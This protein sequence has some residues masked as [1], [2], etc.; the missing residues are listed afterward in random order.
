ML[1]TRPQRL[2]NGSLLSAA[3]HWM[4]QHGRRS[5]SSTKKVNLV[6][7][8]RMRGTASKYFLS[9][10]IAVVFCAN[11]PTF[12]MYQIDAGRTLTNGSG[13]PKNLRYHESMALSLLPPGGSHVAGDLFSSR[14]D[15]GLLEDNAAFS[16]SFT[17][18]CVG[19][20]TEPPLAPAHRCRGASHLLAHLSTCRPSH[21]Y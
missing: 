19:T 4:R 21:G 2:V 10:K 16:R 18:I 6:L 9:S 1:V 8:I 5:C 3:V 7:W 15:T 14:S 12:P 17:P 13:V 20:G 11:E